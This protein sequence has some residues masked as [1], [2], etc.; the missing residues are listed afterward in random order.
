MST[1]A[2]AKLPSI[3]VGDTIT[4]DGEAHQVVGI[5]ELVTEQSSIAFRLRDTC[6]AYKL[7]L[8]AALYADLAAAACGGSA[9]ADTRRLD[10]ARKRLKKKTRG[11]NTG[12]G[13]EG[14]SGSYLGLPFDPTTEPEPLHLVAVVDPADVTAS[15]DVAPADTR[16][17]IDYSAALQGLTQQALERAQTLERHVREVATGFPTGVVGSEPR[18]EYD[19]AV[20][21]LEG[22]VQAKMG[23]LGTSRRTLFRH[24]AAWRADG[25]WGL[26]DDRSKRVADPLAGLDHRIVDAI[27]DQADAERHQ[28]TGTYSRFRRRLAARLAISAPDLTLPPD[29]TL[30]PKVTFL[31]AG[32]YTFDNATTRRTH[33]R[34]PSKTYMHAR[35]DRPGQ[36]V[37]MDSTKL[38][39]TAYD[40]V[41]DVDVKVQ[42]TWAVDLNTRTIG[43]ARLSPQAVKNVDAALLLADMLRPEPMRPHWQEE[44]SVRLLGL[45]VGT[46]IDHDERFRGAAAK[47]VIYPETVLVDNDRVF[48]SDAFERGCELFGINDQSARVMTPTDKAAVEASFRSLGA[49]FS[50]HVAG[51]TGP[52]P[53]RRGDLTEEQA[54]WTVAELEE[55]LTYY[56]VAIYQRTPHS[57]LVA[58][59]QPSRRLS[60]NQ[61]YAASVTRCGW[62]A[63]PIAD[64]MYFQ[65]LPVRW[66]KIHPYGVNLNYRVHDD[67]ILRYYA[68]KPS[69]YARPLTAKGRRGGS[70]HG[71]RRGR[72]KTLPVRYDPRDL[73]YAYFYAWDHH[74]WYGL[75]W[76]DAPDDLQPF[77]DTYYRTLRKY[78]RDHGLNHKSGPAIAQALSEL[79][80]AMDAEENWTA[81]TRRELS[82]LAERAR[83]A[84]RDR[85]ASV[86]LAN[87]EELDGA[88]PGRRRTKRPQPSAP[89]PHD[90]A[91]AGS[92][93]IDIAAARSLRVVRND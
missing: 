58:P 62:V 15:Q 46:L 22:R 30:R 36:A 55:F 87:Q 91:G 74:A 1:A 77:S 23:E 81:T 10:Q 63:A 12:P 32:R 71:E 73:T 6:G 26:V 49:K 27:L 50:Q 38:D 83:A 18:P 69:P 57:A 5:E 90:S 76:I 86:R 72:G 20:T 59:A 17:R 79:Q 44:L 61:A 11:R 53:V 84:A 13:S 52:N 82:I 24:L 28:S 42:M 68:R 60:P 56:I 2:D 78:M 66:V 40:P 37:L 25:L 21:D 85:A 51:Y 65:L 75:K 29:S 8:A 35:A 54:R 7:V 64:D 33:D 88:T 3:G 16:R 45:P 48:V 47:P 70:Q 80:H 43:A 31:V 4:Y 41:N 67:D 92:F 19:P 9:P 34:K 39:I 89:E 93:D 14:R